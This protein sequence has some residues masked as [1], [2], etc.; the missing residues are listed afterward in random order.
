MFPDPQEK[1]V[2]VLEEEEEDK[3]A[4]CTSKT[5]AMLLK[6]YYAVLDTIIATMSF[7]FL[8]SPQTLWSIPSLRLQ[9]QTKE[10]KQAHLHTISMHNKTRL[11]KGM[12]QIMQLK[13]NFSAISAFQ[14]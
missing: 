11:N 5:Q 13:V 7:H 14:Q 4:S 10:K 3:D 1:H 2:T 9:F 12:P 8:Y 6:A